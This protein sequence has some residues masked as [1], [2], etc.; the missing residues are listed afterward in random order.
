MTANRNEDIGSRERHLPNSSTSGAAPADFR[1]NGLVG[2][3]IFVVE[4]AVTPHPA[5]RNRNERGRPGTSVIHEGESR[6]NLEHAPILTW[7]HQSIRSWLISA[8]DG[9][10]LAV[11]DVL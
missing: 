2:D 11:K 6:G 8:V 4:T 5:F 7:S 1:Q 9:Q 3:S 10:T